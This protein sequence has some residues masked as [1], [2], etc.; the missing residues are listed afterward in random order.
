MM[1]VSDKF[2]KG[3][4]YGPALLRKNRLEKFNK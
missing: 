1:G 2:F 3:M 4:K